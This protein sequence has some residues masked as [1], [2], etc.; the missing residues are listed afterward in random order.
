MDIGQHPIHETV[1]FIPKYEDH[2]EGYDFDGQVGSFL[3]AV[4]GQDM[5]YQLSFKKFKLHSRLPLK[6]LKMDH[7][8]CQWKSDKKG[9]G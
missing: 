3:D 4:V 5:F 7:M 6:V 1:S 9:F 8:H 2:E